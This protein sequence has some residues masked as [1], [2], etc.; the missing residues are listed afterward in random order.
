MRTD[1][2]VTLHPPR[3]PA[4]QVTSGQNRIGAGRAQASQRPSRMTVASGC[5]FTSRQARIRTG[6]TR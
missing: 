2:T 6:R 1:V 5:S 4:P 3:L